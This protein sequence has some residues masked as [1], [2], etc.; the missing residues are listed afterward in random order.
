MQPKN[1]TPCFSGDTTK[2]YI[3]LGILGM[4]GYTQP[5]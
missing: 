1:H 2:I 4:H 3:I 5:K